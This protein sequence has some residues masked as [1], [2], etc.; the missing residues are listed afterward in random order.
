[1]TT[2][3][4][5]VCGREF[6]VQGNYIRKTC[7]TKCKNILISRTETGKRGS[8]LRR[9]QMKENNPMSNSETAK[10]MV[11][12]RRER[13]S[14]QNCFLVRG[15]NGHF[16]KPQIVLKN[17]LGTGWELE[18]PIPTKAPKAEHLYPTNYKVDL[19]LPDLKLAIEVDGAGHNT[20]SQRLL[21][22]KKVTFLTSIGWNVLRFT[23]EEIMTN[24]SSVISVVKNLIEKL[25]KCTTLK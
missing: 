20:K 3:Q 1:M 13:G 5:Q 6:Q 15:G 10:K 24:S 21:D 16:T 25:S 4:C 18:Y 19:A 8:E 12:T 9:R 23:N 14:Y 7:S 2:T 11:Q 22:E 17:L